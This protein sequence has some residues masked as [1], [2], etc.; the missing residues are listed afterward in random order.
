MRRD[1]RGGYE[2]VEMRRED[3]KDW[4]VHNFGK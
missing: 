3:T 4:P 2:K 1:T